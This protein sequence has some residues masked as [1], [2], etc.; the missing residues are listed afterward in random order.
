MGKSP[1][2]I[3]REI[4]RLR[5]ES[6]IIVDELER[7]ATLPSLARGMT[8]TVADRANLVAN[9][10]ATMVEGAA[11]TVSRLADEM[12]EPVRQHPFAATFASVGL[13]AGVMGFV[14][15]WVATIRQ[16]AASAQATKQQ[17]GSLD[18][19]SDNFRGLTQQTNGTHSNVRMVPVREEP[20]MV[21]RLLWVGVASVM[22]TLGSM[23]FKRMT[24]SVWR[25][26][27]HEEP[28]KG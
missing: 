8:S 18:R 21:K 19:I 1:D 5:R 6:D 10:A 26:A 24:A 2:D 28:P 22:T 12:P 15:S 4:E 14:F 25:S 16:P 11:S 27:M 17:R 20:S 9:E 23:L 13:L 7:R 3:A